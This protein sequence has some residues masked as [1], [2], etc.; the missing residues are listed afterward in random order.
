MVLRLV[1]PT[2]LANGNP[3]LKFLPG[4]WQ[5]AQETAP[6]ELKRL[7]KKSL[8]PSVVA[9]G[10]SATALE[11][12]GFSGSRLPSQRPRRA[13]IVSVLQPASGQST[14]TIV[15]TPIASTNPRLTR[16]ALRLIVS[17]L[18]QHE[19]K[20]DDV[21]FAAGRDLE[22]DEPPA[23][24][25]ELHAL[26]QIVAV[27]TVLGDNRLGWHA[28][29]V[30]RH[31]AMDGDSGVLDRLSIRCF[32]VQGPGMQ[33]VDG[34]RLQAWRVGA[35]VETLNR[36]ADPRDV[37]VGRRGVFVGHPAQ[38]EREPDPGYHEQHAKGAYGPPDP[39]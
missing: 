4:T 7:S 27:A 6:L 38:H 1:V 33:L 39:A 26:D 11:G 15:P 29:T 18:F 8:C 21:L 24:H 19:V 16:N 2:P 28:M 30:T 31:V 25:L 5:L 12:S 14:E 35:L 10:S 22:L 23:G 9:R 3:S 37:Q 20:A 34:D 17:P 13:E 36:H 32:E